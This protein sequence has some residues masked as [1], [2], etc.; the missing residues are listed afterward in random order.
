MNPQVIE[1]YEN[2]FKNEIMQKQF[3]GARKTLK[4]LFEQLGGQDE[5]HQTDL[6]T[7]YKNVRK[8]LIG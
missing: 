1:Y 7:A 2:L 6:H 8:E 4:E 3:D 5:A